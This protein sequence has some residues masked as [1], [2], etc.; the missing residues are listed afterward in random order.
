MTQETVTI[1]ETSTPPAKINL[2]YFIN[3][4]VAFYECSSLEPK[5]YLFYYNG[6][7][8]NITG[9]L[10]AIGFEDIKLLRKVSVSD[11]NETITWNG[12]TKYQKLEN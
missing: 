2:D 12:R 5:R 4:I 1:F 6:T 10:S 3:D 8:E 7:A 11:S 9:F